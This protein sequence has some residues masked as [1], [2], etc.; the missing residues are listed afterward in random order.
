MRAEQ[1]FGL[2]VCFMLVDWI[3]SQSSFE[4][5]DPQ[6][7]DQF[8]STQ[9][10][11]K[12]WQICTDGDWGSKCPSG[13]RMQGLI[14]TENQ[15]NDNRIQGLQRMLDMYSTAF[16]NTYITVT[17]AVNRIRQSLS[18]MGGLG[19]TY[20]QLVDYLNSRLTILQNK[21][22]SQNLRLKRLK[23]NILEQF[24]VVLRLEVDIDIKIQSCKGS[25]ATSVVY[26]VNKESN[27]QM[28]KSLQSMTGLKLDRIV[29]VKPIHK[30]K[31]SLMKKSKKGTSF[32]F[33]IDHEY[34]RFWEDVHTRL[35]TIE[36]D[37][38]HATSH[39]DPDFYKDSF[40][41]ST[42]MTPNIISTIKGVDTHTTSMKGSIVPLTHGLNS[43]EKT[44]ASLKHGSLDNRIEEPLFTNVSAKSTP[45]YSSS[46]TKTNHSVSG[47]KIV[48]N[49]TFTK[50]NDIQTVNQGAFSYLSLLN[51]GQ[52]NFK[53]IS[54]QQR[55]KGSF[56]NLAQ[57]KA[58]R[59]SDFNNY[60]T[61]G[62]FN[63]S[64]TTNN[65]KHTCASTEEVT[66]S[67]DNAPHTESVNGSCGHQ[68]TNTKDS[69]NFSKVSNT[70]QVTLDSNSSFDDE[71]GEEFLNLHA[72]SFK[73]QKIEDYIGKDCNDI[74][75]KHAFGDEDGLFK[76]KPTGSAGVV[77]VYCDQST[78][79]GGWVLV[80]QRMD[81]S[82]HFNRSWAEYKQGFG[83]IDDQGHGDIWLGNEILH[84]L[85][86]K[87]SIFRV[88]LE[89]W[90]GNEVFAEYTV[91][92][93][94]ESESYRL[95]IADYGGNAGDAL[96]SGISLDSEHTSHA[97]MKFSTYD[98]DNDKWEE[99]CAEFYGGG[100]WYNSCQSANLN[101][102]YY[103]GGLYDPRNNM[104]YEIENGVV[105]VPFKGGDYSLKVVRVKT[106]SKASS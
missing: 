7:G 3:E 89:D 96:I 36:N 41:T 33:D 29:D 55:S 68:S 71:I 90:S 95:N 24:K 30:L 69:K 43:T 75:Q 25:C 87:E 17:E 51:S 70:T 46:A 16:R 54:L 45:S 35:I 64:I 40:L 18:R 61:L 11:E 44:Y 81:G 20:Y 42:P 94:S 26:K 39:L 8:K 49:Q 34:P 105:W 32:K 9:C 93:G 1:A 31:M 4:P 23:N 66:S 86:Q 53:K 101:G 83:S 6:S 13:C 72:P 47:S 100:W 106:R 97:S 27:A 77:T 63:N 15:Q 21:T 19:D 99:N 67:K 10:P 5:R 82:V 56:V 59:S 78:G 103:N 79:L 102:I 84:L 73:V 92:V 88:E 22:K 57:K 85:T 52:I 104:P 58:N 65:R 38:P 12:K 50:H 91:T 80:Q 62:H 37:V 2:F 74:I 48:I 28:E 98:R 60:S 14:E 76:I